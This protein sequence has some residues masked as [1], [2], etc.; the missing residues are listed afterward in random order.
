MEEEIIIESVTTEYVVD[1]DIYDLLVEYIDP[2]EVKYYKANDTIS[3]SFAE[4]LSVFRLIVDRYLDVESELHVSVATCIVSNLYFI[5][6]RELENVEGQNVKYKMYNGIEDALKLIDVLEKSR[7]NLCNA[8]FNVRVGD[9]QIIPEDGYD[10]IQ[11]AKKLRMKNLNPTTISVG[12]TEVLSILFNDTISCREQLLEIKERYSTIELSKVDK[13]LKK[14]KVTILQNHLK[15]LFEFLMKYGDCAR[16]SK[17]YRKIVNILLAIKLFDE[18]SI[19][20]TTSTK[21]LIERVSSYVKH[22]K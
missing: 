8:N 17:A 1:K 10:G 3:K 6:E 11:L 2:V 14:L 20:S 19:T 22:C 16:P 21:D 15:P 5:Y 4:D 9:F 12:G 13:E 7:F 18:E